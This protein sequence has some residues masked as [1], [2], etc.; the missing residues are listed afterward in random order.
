MS[1]LLT[2]LTTDEASVKK[3]F[4]QL[5]PLYAGDKQQVLA[6]LKNNPIA[7]ANADDWEVELSETIEIVQE[8]KVDEQVTIGMIRKYN[9]IRYTCIQAHTTQSD[10]IPSIVPALWKAMIEIPP[11]QQYPDWVQPT[12][13]HDAYNIG[14]RVMYNNQN[15][16]STINSNVWV[17]GAVQGLW[18]II[19]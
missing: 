10:W 3:A 12:G 18:I 14:A 13:A 19:N 11:T 17:P 4:N 1:A 2:Y 8:W 5:M 6:A 7:V 9:G 16:E 15:W